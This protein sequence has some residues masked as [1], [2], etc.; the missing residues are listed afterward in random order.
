MASLRFGRRSVSSYRGEDLERADGA[1]R[2]ARADAATESGDEQNTIPR[3]ATSRTP[4]TRRSNS[5]RPAGGT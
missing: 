2:S 5:V 4:P 3:C 1:T